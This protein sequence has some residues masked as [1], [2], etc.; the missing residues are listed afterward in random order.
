[1]NPLLSLLP[2]AARPYAKSVI[3]ALGLVLSVLAVVTP[4]ASWLP[5]VIQIATVLGVYGVPNGDAEDDTFIP[6]D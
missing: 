1:M 3:A 4:A 5:V 2:P 6:E